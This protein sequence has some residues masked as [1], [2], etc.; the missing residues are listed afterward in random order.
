MKLYPEQHSS[1]AEQLRRP[2]QPPLLLHVHGLHS[3]I[4][5]IH[6]SVWRRVSVQRTMAVRRR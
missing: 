4:N 1:L 2:L 3:G 5:T 6:H